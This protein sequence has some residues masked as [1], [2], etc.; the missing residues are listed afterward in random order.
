MSS[1]HCGQ[2]RL[3]PSPRCPC[4]V[5]RTS[6]RGSVPSRRSRSLPTWSTPPPRARLWNRRVGPG[7]CHLPQHPR[8]LERLCERPRPRGPRYTGATARAWQRRPERVLHLFP[9]GR[10]SQKDQGLSRTRRRQ[11]HRRDRRA[12]TEASHEPSGLPGTD[13]ACRPV[14]CSARAQV[15]RTRP[16][17]G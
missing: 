5:L 7:L 13:L 1:A 17:T 12:G 8:G 3:Q 4:L 11:A 6:L 2:A 10:Q 14:N 16:E 9:H 15:T